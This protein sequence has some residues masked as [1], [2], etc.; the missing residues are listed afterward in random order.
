MKVGNIPQ[1]IL[2]AARQNLG[3]ADKND[4]SKD[5]RIE[6]MSSMELIERLSAWELD[7]SSWA[8]RYISAYLQLEA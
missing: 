3:A 5:R 4:S 2:E 1:F 8:R 6:Q 7:D